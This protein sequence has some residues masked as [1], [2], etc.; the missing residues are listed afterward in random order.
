MPGQFSFSFFFSLIIFITHSDACNNL[1]CSFLYTPSREPSISFYNG[2][3]VQLIQ[4]VALTQEGCEKAIITN[5]LACGPAA[6]KCIYTVESVGL[7][8]VNNAGIGRSECCD[9]SGND[10]LLSFT[11]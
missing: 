6:K 10:L 5:Y 2:N 3:F 8:C 4:M 11:S 7:Q 9:S 1:Y